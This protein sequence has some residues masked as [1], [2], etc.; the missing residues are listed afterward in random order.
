MSFSKL[1][2]ALSTLP[3]AAI[4]DDVVLSVLKNNATI[5]AAG[6]GSGKTLLVSALLAECASG[7][8]VVCVPRKFLA[9]HAAETIATLAGVEVGGLVGYGVGSGSGDESRFSS[10][11]KLLF[12]TYGY[13]IASGLIRNAQTLVLDEVHE[14]S[15]DISLA[16]ALIHRRI[17]KGESLHLLEMSATVNAER[18]AAYWASVTSHKVFQTDGKTFPCERR[19]ALALNE[20]EI[21][22][23]VRGLIV[24]DNR[25]G[26]VVFRPSVAEVNDTAEEIQNALAAAGVSVEVTTMYGE[27]AA[28][29]RQAAVK[30]PTD[31]MP[32][33]VVSTN[34]LESGANVPW[35]DAAVS[36]GTGKELVAQENG[37]I[38]LDTVALPQW[39]LIQQ[40]GSVQ[41]L[42]FRH[43][44]ALLIPKVG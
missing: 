35:L 29:E 40:L 18:Q 17:S 43:L 21:A 37:A 39:R 42:P 20:R 22:E 7:Q 2:S 23:V 31:G 44:R 19:E 11:T 1:F 26:I 28:A 36:C 15:T 41:S 27:M 16:R 34:V 33:V 9:V 24:C 32:K 25:K 13:A 4:A 38:M 8:V 30:A 10:R 5:L 14:A 3:T 6:T 12:V